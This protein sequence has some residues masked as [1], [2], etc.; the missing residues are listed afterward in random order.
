MVVARPRDDTTPDASSL[1]RAASSV[2]DQPS[3]LQERE[4]E[5]LVAWLSAWASHWPDSFAKHF[6]RPLG[7]V[8][9]SLVRPDDDPNR[10]LKL[11]R[12]ALA[13]LADI[14]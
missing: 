1:A 6:G 14:L 12:I 9:A 4:R 8:V 7:E 13:H 10:Y 5:A 2:L 11:R 3:L